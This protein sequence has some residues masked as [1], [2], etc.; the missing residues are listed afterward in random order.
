DATHYGNWRRTL[1][2]PATGS[3]IPDRLLEAQC[4]GRRIVICEDHP[5]TRLGLRETCVRLGCDVVGETALGEEAIELVESL[6]PDLL[7]LDLHLPGKV[8]GQGVHQELRRRGL[9][10]KVLVSTT[11]CDTASFF[12][13]INQPDGPEGV[14]PKDTSLYEF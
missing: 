11:Y 10:T 14:L 3:S 7:I 1:M 8:A 5:H 2:E 9:P 6:R 13:W 4:R 12:D